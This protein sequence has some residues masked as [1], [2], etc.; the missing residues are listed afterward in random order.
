M[1]RVSVKDRRPYDYVAALSDKASHL[2]VGDPASGQVALGPIIRGDIAPYPL[3]A[4]VRGGY[5]PVL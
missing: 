5:A 1:T 2:P 4:P 3:S